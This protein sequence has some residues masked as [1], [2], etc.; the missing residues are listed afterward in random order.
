MISFFST[1]RSVKL[2]LILLPLVLSSCYLRDISLVKTPPQNMIVSITDPANEDRFP[3]S[4]VLQIRAEVVS[5]EPIQK[6]ELWVDGERIEELI[7]GSQ[8]LSYLAHTWSWSS[9]ELGAH[10]L[11]VRAYNKSG[12][13]AQSNVLNITSIQDPGFVVMYTTVEGDTLEQ[14][15]LLNESSVSLIL[16]ANPDLVADGPLPP[17]TLIRVPVGIDETSYHLPSTPK[18]AGKNWVSPAGIIPAN[19]RLNFNESEWIA[20]FLAAPSVSA[21]VQGCKVT[22]NISDPGSNPTGYSIYRLNQGGQSFVKIA[23]VSGSNS[24]NISYLDDGLAPGKYQYYAASYTSGLFAAKIETPS[25]IVN[26][27]ISQ[28]SCTGETLTVVDLLPAAEIFNQ[29]YLYLSVNGKNWSRF[30]QGEFIFMKP[31]QPVNLAEMAA[32][33]A[34]DASGSLTLQGEGWGWINGEL[35]Y[36]ETFKRT[37]T[38]SPAAASKSPSVMNGYFSTVL[39]VRGTPIVD[40]NA[41]NWIT[42]IG[43][44]KYSNQIF[45]W[46]TNTGADGGVWQVATSPFFDAKPSL[47][48]ACLVLTGSVFSGSLQTPTEFP[49]DFSPLAPEILKISNKPA[50][51]VEIGK[52]WL[53][54]LSPTSPPYSVQSVFKSTKDQSVQFVVSPI[55]FDPCNLSKNA[56]G[57]RTYYIRVLPTKNKQLL[58]T[59]SNTVVFKYSSPPPPVK[60]DY[61]PTDIFYDIKIIEFTELNNPEYNFASCVKIVK[62]PYYPST[63]PKWGTKAPGAIVCPASYKGG[64]NSLLEDIA[65]FIED[66]VNFIS[67]LYNDLSDFVTMLVEKLNPFCYQAQFIAKAVGEGEKEVQQA[68]HAVAVIAVTAAKTY[69]GLPPS[70]PNF[71]QLTSMGKDYVVELAVDELESN[72][73]PC[74]QEC[75]DLIEKGV[76][77]SLEQVKAAVSSHSCVSEAEAHEKGQEPLCPP[78]G[79]VTVPDPRGVPVPPTAVIEVYRRPG[80]AAA[81][82][83]QPDSCMASLSG[84]ASNN[85]YVGQTKTIWFGQVWF[86]WQGTALKDALLTANVPIPSLAPGKSVQIPV[87]LKPVPFWLPGHYAW[88]GKW[89]NV[90]DSDDWHLLYKGANLALTAGGDC[91]FSGKYDPFTN[92]AGE[93]K[94]YGPLGDAYAIPCWP[95]CP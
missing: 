5:D 15:A 30:P 14:I 50:S 67:D 26:A 72:G 94:Y 70:L 37:I 46:G 43:F 20:P 22:L 11:I 88:Y 73:I 52:V 95:Y 87:V 55:S 56:D 24:G 39:E 2:I 34:P 62:N 69:V 32:M 51:E 77:Y 81:N 8:I 91:S 80:S 60:I 17:D 54:N 33:V 27:V 47:N 36:L 89:Q 71:D 82:I 19:F 42:E 21:V 28:T 10:A 57:G 29:V 84:I 49:I 90:A 58:P 78:S 85:T 7:P 40:A 53:S 61:A 18:V 25:N 79:I 3:V 93:T 66:T 63:Y 13:S 83:L 23:S 68:C 48:P 59:P 4:G 64:S 76:D 16:I 92:V 1:N 6:M 75:K 65:D 41:Y 44:N 9:G 31:D 45:R 35:I 12:G 38:T 86:T 74:P